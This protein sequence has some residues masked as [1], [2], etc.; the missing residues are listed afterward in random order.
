MTAL[1]PTT[2]GSPVMKLGSPVINNG[3]NIETNGASTAIPLA[4]RIGQV[5]DIVAESRARR[6]R[7]A[8]AR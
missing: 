6:L 1:Q 4:P 5:A 7:E 2:A 3:A 8:E